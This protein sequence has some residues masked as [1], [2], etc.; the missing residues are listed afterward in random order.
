MRE[1]T[2]GF[3]KRHH[4]F[5]PTAKSPAPLLAYVTAFFYIL[6]TLYPDSH[7]LMAAWSWVF[8]WQV[9][10]FCPL[11]WFM[12]QLWDHRC[13]YLLGNG[14]DQMLYDKFENSLLCDIHLH[15]T[16][17]N[18]LLEPQMNNWFIIFQQSLL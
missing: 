10:L 2:F 15:C 13:L 12:V 6:F 4:K 1:P 8:V 5:M 17:Y 9:G 7:S 3:Y 14:F 11:I 18:I 16:T